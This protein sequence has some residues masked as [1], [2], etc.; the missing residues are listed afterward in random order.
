MK[1]NT[2]KRALFLAMSNPEEPSMNREEYLDAY[3][4]FMEAV[5]TLPTDEQD[6]PNTEMVMLPSYA[7]F[8]MLNELIYDPCGYILRTSPDIDLTKPFGLEQARKAIC[9]RKMWGNG[10]TDRQLLD[11]LDAVQD[12]WRSNDTNPAINNPDGSYR[13]IRCDIIHKLYAAHMEERNKNNKLTIDL[14]DY[15]KVIGLNEFEREEFLG[16]IDEAQR[17]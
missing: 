8:C 5:K 1:L 12:L 4:E 11:A 7:L 13:D 3:D 17:G 16:I 2:I 9:E 10:V 14:D 15:C 6:D